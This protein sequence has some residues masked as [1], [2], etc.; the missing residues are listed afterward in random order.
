MPARS[1]LHVS[2]TL[3]FF[4]FTCY[5]QQPKKALENYIAASDSAFKWYTEAIVTNKDGKLYEVSLVSQKWQEIR[6][7]HRLIIYFPN[8]AKQT[9]TLLLVLRHIYNRNAGIASLK[10]ISDSTSTPAAFLYDIPNQPLFNGKEE[11]DLQAYTFSQYIKSG[12]E[13]WPLL[14]PMVKSV[15]SAINVIQDLSTRAE[16]LTINKFIVAGHS[17]RGHTSW[18]TAAVDNRIKGI[19]PI[20]ID[21]LNAPEQMPHHLN[22]FGQFSTPSEDATEFL[23]E[24]RK[25]LGSSLIQMIDPYSYKE[26]LTIQKLIIS[27]T[28]DEYFPSDAL[29]LYWEGLKGEKSIL[30]LSNASHARADSDPRINPTAFAFV[31]A[32]AMGSAL[33][34]FSWEWKRTNQRLQ[35]TINADTTATKAILWQATSHNNDFRT[36]LWSA[37]PIRQVDNGFKKQFA[38]DVEE[39]SASNR[40]FYGEIEFKQYGHSFLLSTQIYRCSGK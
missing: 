10:V 6:W 12:N 33:P 15:V 2:L 1:V 27:A 22:A 16:K 24:L 23:K 7:T 36:S 28:N 4:Y 40:L 25:P 17:K 34:R 8:K 9:N 29:N 21:V 14:F 11:D 37:S 19:I 18:L 39:K 26:R 20:A 32:I 5:S 13:S 31:R 3:L 38:I 35:L 30:Y